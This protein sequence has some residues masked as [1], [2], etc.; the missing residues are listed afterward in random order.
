VRRTLERMRNR[1]Q[2]ILADP[3]DFI[4][5]Q[6]SIP[7]DLDDLPEDEQMAI[8]EAIEEAAINFDPTALREDILQLGKLID[9]ACELEKREVESKLTRLKQL[10]TEEQVFADPTMKVLIFTEH[11]DTLD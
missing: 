10:L 6:M 7:D 1:R 3:R 8:I 4:R 9:H 2:K 5:R 11:K